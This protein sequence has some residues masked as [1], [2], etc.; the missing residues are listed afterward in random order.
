MRDKITGSLEWS[1]PYYKKVSERA[2]LTVLRGLVHLRDVKSLTSNLGDLLTAISSV[3][4]L[5]AMTSQVDDKD[6]A[7][8]LESL[9]SDLSLLVQSEF[10]SILKNQNSFNMHQAIKQ[11]KVVLINLDGQTYSESAKKFGRLLLDDLRAASGAIVNAVTRSERPQF[12]EI[13]DEFSD[14]VATP[15]LVSTFVGFLN[16]CRGSGIGVIIVHQSLGDFKDATTRTQVMDSTE[17]LFSFVQKDPETCETL[18]SLVGT[19]KVWKDT[20]QIEDGF[21]GTNRTGQG[22][23]VSARS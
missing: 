9:K 12:T 16:R 10:G 6:M 17:T 8:D 20:E 11:K 21:F 15:D 2:L 1:E 18:A 19:R 23:R 22:S 5:T 13:I 7:Q 4:G 3:Q 14:I